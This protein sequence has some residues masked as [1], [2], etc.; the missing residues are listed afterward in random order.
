M[1]EIIKLRR[2]LHRHPELSGSEFRSIERIT[3]FIKK[4]NPDE[5][6]DLANTGRAFVFNSSDLHSGPTLLIRAEIDALPIQEES[7]LEYRSAVNG[8]AHLCGHDGHTSIV[9][10]LA[11]K[12]S[13]NPPQKGRIVLL[14]QPAEETG[15][16]AK[17]VIADPRFEK[18][19][20]DY[21]YA[22]HNIPGIEKNTIV[23]REG[24]FAA[25]SRGLT[26]KFYGKT[27]HAAE[28]ENGKNPAVAISGIILAVDDLMK[29]HEFQSLSLATV[30][31][32]KIGDIAFG[33]SAGYGELRM[34]LRA[35]EEEDM[36]NLVERVENFIHYASQAYSL[37]NEIEYS[38]VFPVT[39]TSSPCSEV[40]QN[41]ARQNQFKFR[42][43]EGPFKWSEDF[44]YFSKICDTGFFGLGSGLNQPALHNPDFDFPED[45]LTTG[46]E[47]FFS[48]CNQHNYKQ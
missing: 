17:D 40:I 37:K 15:Q 31:H 35:F 28:P 20:P 41:A 25:A 47:M 18:I 2:D 5:I 33:T 27:S 21:A 11:E 29:N 26:A 16:G 44:G 8:I 34:T 10:G 3:S 22:L 45:I 43:M 14:F 42:R 1:Q 36:K 23:G 13:A 4:Y 30:V 32:V 39:N 6:I 24:S 19:K 9:A 38:E 48:I 46:I 12:L 7:D